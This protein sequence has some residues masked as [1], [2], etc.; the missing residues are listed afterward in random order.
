[1]EEEIVPMIFDGFF[2]TRNN[3]TGAGLAFC[4]RT[5]QSFDG[6][7]RVSSE[8]GKFTRFTLEFPHI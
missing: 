1:M 2:T 4:K 3:G 8:I 6:D 7:I 5:M